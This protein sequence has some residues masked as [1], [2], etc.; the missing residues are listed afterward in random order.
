MV[1]LTGYTIHEFLVRNGNTFQDNLLFLGRSA[2]NKR[3]AVPGGWHE[4]DG[5]FEYHYEIGPVSL[6]DASVEH[7]DYVINLN[8]IEGE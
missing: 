8:E 6:T 7:L 5:F 2:Y 3:F 4:D 1:R